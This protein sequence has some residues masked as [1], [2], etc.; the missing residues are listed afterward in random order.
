MTTNQP[1]RR[2]QTR[3]KSKR[4]GGYSDTHASDI[5]EATTSRR[6][7]KRKKGERLTSNINNDANTDAQATSVHGSNASAVDSN[8]AS[9][10]GNGAANTNTD[11]QATSAH[12]N[13][14]AVDSN[15][16]S[17]EGNVA[18]NTNIDVQATSVHGNA[19]AVDS[20][21]VSG[22]GKFEVDGQTITPE[23]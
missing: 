15:I 11:A 23:E 22:E 5:H 13:A 8:S 18:A 17:G 12:D 21:S 1:K 16:V 4:E 20:N 10:E 19:S 14:S 2:Y 6:L 7:R 9:G 3:Q